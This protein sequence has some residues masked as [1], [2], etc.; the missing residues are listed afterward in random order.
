MAKRIKKCFNKDQL[1]HVWAQ[2][3]QSDGYTPRNRMF[4][5]GDKIYS[6]GQHYLAAKI[7]TKADGTKFALVN[8]S[9][10]S[11][12]T[13]SH[14]AS[15]RDSLRGLMP[16]FECPN[17]D[18]LNDEVNLNY[19]SN[20]V[21]DSISGILS[22]IKV[23]S[24]IQTEIHDCFVPEYNSFAN[25]IGQPEIAMPD[26]LKQVLESHLK[27]R[28]ER[29]KELNTPDMIVKKR[30]VTA[31]KEAARLA[32]IAVA[33]AELLAKFEPSKIEWVKTGDNEALKVIKDVGV[34]YD[35]F[36]IKNETIIVTHRGPRFH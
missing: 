30:A 25:L 29:Y 10:Y 35:L 14:L 24:E 16:Y 8:S 26:D 34:D 20:S 11:V 1:C 2:Q 3:T 19:Y 4:F 5:Y 36:R 17:P 7:Y 12:T 18:D 9:K 31:K 22:T 21:A 27:G 13:A 33:H 6:Y 15:I 32:K 23:T 28:F